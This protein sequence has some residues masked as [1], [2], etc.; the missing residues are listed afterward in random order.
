M[1]K[2]NYTVFTYGYLA[3]GWD[4]GGPLGPLSGWG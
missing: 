4:G 1:I 2:K 3:G